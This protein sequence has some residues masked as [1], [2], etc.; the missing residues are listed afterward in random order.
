MCL[1]TRAP[2]DV[3]GYSGDYIAGY[4]A[5]CAAMNAAM[6]ATGASSLF[7]ALAAASKVIG[8]ASADA[9]RD[10]ADTQRN[11]DNTMSTGWKMMSIHAARASL[12]CVI[13]SEEAV[14]SAVSSGLRRIKTP[15][16]MSLETVISA[17]LTLDSHF[18]VMNTGG[19]CWYLSRVW[20]LMCPSAPLTLAAFEW[21]RKTFFDLISQCEDKTVDSFVWWRIGSDYLRADFLA[22]AQESFPGL[23][24]PLWDIVYDYLAAPSSAAIRQEILSLI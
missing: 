16:D 2:R 12:R 11:I 14:Y 3:T 5:R 15:S 23:L 10:A 9:A 24:R 22:R 8:E 13:G 17:M 21:C 6:E 7:D 20:S 18:K 1:V 19:K 4:A